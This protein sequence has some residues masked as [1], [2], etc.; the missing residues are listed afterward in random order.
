MPLPIPTQSQGGVGGAVGGG[1]TPPQYQPQTYT[2]LVPRTQ[3]PGQNAP[4]STASGPGVRPGVVNGIPAGMREV[5]SYDAQGNRMR[6]LV[7]IDEPQTPQGGAQTPTSGTGGTGPVAGGGPTGGA[8]G[9]T[10]GNPATGG[11][12]NPS[13]GPIDPVDVVNGAPTLNAFQ[14]YQDA[15][16]QQARRQLDPVW[17]ANQRQFEQTMINK[18]LSP[19]TAA[20]NQ[21][22]DQ[23]NRGKNDQY[24]AAQNQALQQ[25]LGAQ[26]Q[27]FSQN[28]QESA[29]ANALLRAR[30]QNNTSLNIAGLNANTSLTAADIG[31]QN[32]LDQLGFNQSQAGVASDQWNRQFGQSQQQWADQFGQSQAAQ[33]FAQMMGMAGFDRDTTWGN[34]TQNNQQFQQLASLFGALQP[35]AQGTNPVDY[36]GA[37][38]MNQQGQQQQYQAGVGQANQQNASYM[39]LLASLFCDEEIKTVTGTPDPARCLEI[40]EAIPLASFTYNGD[41]SKTE[42]VGTMAQP[43]NRMLHGSPVPYIRTMDIVGVL[44]GAVKALS[45][46]VNTLE[47]SNGLA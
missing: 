30:E 6:R 31:R 17:E 9:G 11:A 46:R 40:A 32:F 47:A 18:G 37:L 22:L 38:G 45:D 10:G 36:L 34:N 14:Q 1:V 2:P 43:F 28:Y 8:T 42:F 35:Q 7:P 44:L 25:G 23:F 27:A 5:F 4:I 21:A 16:M 13:G 26:Q 41:P 24:N 20:Y 29:L 33:D 19:G 15:A 12:G 39:A 3:R